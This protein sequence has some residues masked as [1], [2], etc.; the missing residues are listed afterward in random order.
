[1]LTKRVINITLWKKNNH[2]W[3]LIA[4]IH[5]LTYNVFHNKVYKNIL[6]YNK[7]KMIKYQQK[8]VDIKYQIKYN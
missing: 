7:K 4:F 6:K 3:V 2:I 1:M 5:K 8:I